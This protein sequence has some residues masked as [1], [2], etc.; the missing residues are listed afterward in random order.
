MKREQPE[1][2]AGVARDDLVEH[3]TLCRYSLASALEALDKERTHSGLRGR[4]TPFARALREVLS[5]TAP[6]P[7]PEAEAPPPREQMPMPAAAD[8]EQQ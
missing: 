6:P 2:F 5:R 4:D 3:L 7:A 8:L 1:E